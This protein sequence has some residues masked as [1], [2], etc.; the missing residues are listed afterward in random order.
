VKIKTKG[1]KS[2]KNK[3]N[4]KMLAI[5]LL[6]LA[7]V[8]CGKRNESVASLNLSSTNKVLKADD[9]PA[10]GPVEKTSELNASAQ[11]VPSAPKNSAGATV[12][13]APALGVDLSKLQ[14][15]IVNG[16]LPGLPGIQVSIDAA[17][18]VLVESIIKDASGKTIA[19]TLAELSKSGMFDEVL[20]QL[21]AIGSKLPEIVTPAIPGAGSSVSLALD[22]NGQT[23]SID[24][25]KLTAEAGGIASQ[26]LE[27][28]SKILALA[29]VAIASK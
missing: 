8:A 28:Y 11:T 4:S 18:K 9:L 25:S 1:G 17:S 14:K 21:Q 23:Y 3:T 6:G 26:L 22:I 16:S 7:S 29:P 24:L 27:I 13:V 2:M 15:V 5:L 12:A 10:P 19:S 20:K